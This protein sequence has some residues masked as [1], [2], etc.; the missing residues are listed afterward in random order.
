MAF[1]FLT[2]FNSEMSL[3]V[4][5]ILHAG[6]IFGCGETAIAFDPIF[7]N[8]FSRNCHAYPSVT[9]DCEQIRKLQ[10][11]AVF[12][13]HYHDDHCS[14]ESLD[15]L[16]RET[17]IYLYCIHE[18]LFSMLR[19]LGF[20]NV[21]PLRLDKSIR[22]GAFEVTPH[23]AL[24]P[25]VDS[26]FHIQAEGL[27][28]LNVVDSWLDPDALG[29]FAGWNR[30]DMVLWP[31]QTLLE[32]DVLAPTQAREASRSI[33]SEWLEQLKLLNPRSIVPSSCQ[34]IHEDW[35]WYNHALFPITYKQFKSDVE[36][37]LPLTP[38][39]R[40]D[41]GSSVKLTSAGIKHAEPLGWVRASA[42]QGAGFEVDYDYK[43]DHVP[44]TTGEIAKHFLELT[45]AQAQRVFHYCQNDLITRYRELGPSTEP[46]FE[47]AVR[48]RLSLFGNNGQI[49]VF[50]YSLRR[51][52]CCLLSSETRGAETN[53][54]TA[55]GQPDWHT[56]VPIM[57]LYAALEAGESLTSMYLRISD[58]QNVDAL[59]DPLIRCLFSGKFAS[60]QKAQL[61]KLQ[62]KRLQLK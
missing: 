6:Y 8:P 29:K 60:Y 3:T 39:I 58:V 31:F 59:E 9:F 37:V 38:V 47:R 10:F 41:P 53:A 30:W 13:S 49:T 23:K 22:V 2:A 16:K 12:I 51:D 11:D 25:D 14:L 28:V 33:P 26:V 46:C 48:W 18:E 7:E 42:E 32:V 17:P 57:K 50:D 36:T 35:S 24:D 5:R 43:I 52:E 54:A 61:S 27:N 56:E 20:T 19:A 40:L 62:L 1:S 4:S 21:Q 34:F 44:P 55:A 15:L 45:P